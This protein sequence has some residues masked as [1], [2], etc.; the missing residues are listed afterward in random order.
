M[1]PSPPDISI[2]WLS[3]TYLTTSPQA[4]PSGTLMVVTVGRRAFGSLTKNSKPRAAIPALGGERKS[5]V[6]KNNE[7]QAMIERGQ[8]EDGGKA[9][10]PLGGKLGPPRAARTCSCSAAAAC[11]AQTFSRPSSARTASASRRAYTTET[12]GSAAARSAVIGQMRCE[13]GA[14]KPSGKMRRKATL[15]SPSPAARHA[16]VVVAAR[17]AVDAPVRA[18]L[19]REGERLR[20]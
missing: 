8:E 5:V 7:A 10:P 16:G 6:Q 12:C 15:M 18:N 4:T 9:G 13:G 3:Y 1:G 20:A 14:C 17:N 2:P 11:R 19:A